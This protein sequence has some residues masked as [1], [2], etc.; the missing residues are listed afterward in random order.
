[1]R[2]KLLLTLTLVL[3]TSLYV[4]TAGEIEIDINALDLTANKEQWEEEGRV[5]TQIEGI[6]I[7]IENHFTVIKIIF[8]NTM[9]RDVKVNINVPKEYISA[10]EMGIVKA[11]G[12]VSII[13]RTGQNYTM[14]S[15]KMHAYQT[16]TLTVSK[17]DVLWGRMKKTVHNWFN[18]VEYNGN[19]V[20]TEENIIV[21]V[22]KEE[23]D[24]EIDNKHAIL[25]YKTDFFGWYY[26]IED[27]SSRDTY[28]YV[29]D[30]GDSY[31]FVVHF[32]GNTTADVKI[33]CFPGA[34]EGFFNWDTFK[35]G[36]ARGFISVQIGIKK[37]IMDIFGDPKPV[38]E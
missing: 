17:G 27:V 37:F 29:D 34:S 5:Q 26:P 28:Y 31:R 35:G 14:I 15:F 32:K 2:I 7:T 21:F 19:A 30:L 9:P 22:E 12:N 1:M 18:Y 25:Q 13:W 24:F 20:G 16:I 36:I 33:H 11:E 6:N 38:Y 10:S 23:T 3:L 8:R 4:A